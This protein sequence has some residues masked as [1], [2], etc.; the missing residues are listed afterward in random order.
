MGTDINFVALLCKNRIKIYMILFCN[1]VAPAAIKTGE[2]FRCMEKNLH[3]SRF[4][5][6]NVRGL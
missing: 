2:T 3:N 6:K 5:C 1:P 4:V